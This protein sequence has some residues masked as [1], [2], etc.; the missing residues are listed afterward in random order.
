VASASGAASGAPPEDGAR[1]DSLREQARLWSTVDRLR[2]ARHWP[3]CC[4]ALVKVVDQ[5]RRLFG[6]A[7]HTLFYLTAF[8]GEV[9]EACQ[10]REA[11][12]KARAEAVTIQARFLRAPAPAKEKGGA[13]DEA[14][15]R[16]QQAIDARR[17]VLGKE[18]PWVGLSLIDRA[19]AEERG[20]RADRAEATLEEA[21]RLF[22]A[23]K[24]EP[25]RLP[26]G[27][28]YK[29]PTDVSFHLLRLRLDRE[30][31]DLASWVPPEFVP[32]L[33]AACEQCAEADRWAAGGD[34]ARARAL[35]KELLSSVRGVLWIESRSSPVSSQLEMMRRMRPV[36]D[37]YLSYTSGAGQK[38]REP[39]AEYATLC[40]LKGSVF[41]HQRRIWLERRHPWM[42]PAFGA[43]D[44]V[45][46]RLAAL[47]GGPGGRSEETN[48]AERLLL[49]HKMA[50]E[51][52]LGR[53]HGR[54]GIL[55]QPAQ[56]SVQLPV[57]AVL[58]DYYIYD[59]FLAKAG[60]EPR[61]ACFV[62]RKGVPTAYLD[63]GLVE[64]VAAALAEWRRAIA[65]GRGESRGVEREPDERPDDTRPQ[66]TLRKQLW[67]PLRPHLD[68][69]EVVLVSPDGILCSLPFAALPGG[70]PRTYLLEEVAVLVA[71]T[72]LLLTPLKSLTEI[73]AGHGARFSAGS[74]PPLAEGPLLVGNV[75]FRRTGATGPAR[76]SPL[77]GTAKEVRAIGDIF[78]E[79]HPRKEAETLTAE[80]ATK[81]AVRRELLRRR[82]A[83][84]ATHGLFAAKARDH[85]VPPEMR[86]ALALAGADDAS[87][88][89]GDGLLTA[90]EVQAM[91]LA[92]MDLA[93][94]S[95]CETALGEAREGEG[96]LGLQR[97][98]Q[99]AGV[100]STITSLW[101]VHDEATRILMVEFYRNV[102]QKKLA[103]GEALRQAQ[104]AMLNGKPYRD[105][106][107]PESE[108]LAPYFWAA[109]V[110]SGTWR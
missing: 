97:A 106:K 81:E 29:C 12:E 2:V 5:E 95:A 46:S 33:K 15:A 84:L 11:A 39:E 23:A 21:Q 28:T 89:E 63:L 57:G 3:E 109:F 71:P 54:L 103:R 86:S 58:V 26:L 48:R 1:D 56:P 18:H 80:R 50:L 93:V 44:D 108:R 67:E 100:R 75:A 61:I 32:R 92:E 83:H 49:V 10:E 9:R 25:E 98:F 38:E 79:S 40:N 74:R 69:A 24:F 85:A 94:L 22:Q 76:F 47:P 16:I 88:M 90:L 43:L 59:R 60:P 8:L 31:G 4:Y 66:E 102:W 101:R 42:Q 68:K 72:P 20:G 55:F 91:D 53:R 37:R 96:V 73:M 27:P 41:L 65:A 87:E 30:K 14:I 64:P 104:L 82:W 52:E 19:L 36:F 13:L 51:A 17:D 70:K 107:A 78:R 62:S 77:P 34:T 45:N 6:E 105:P 99:T 110:L 35:G 7:T